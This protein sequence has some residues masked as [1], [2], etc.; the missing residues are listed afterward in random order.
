MD[1]DRCIY[2]LKK[3]SGDSKGFLSTL[4]TEEVREILTEYVC[5]RGYQDK[6][7]YI[8]LLMESYPIWSDLTDCA[9]S[10][11]RTFFK[12]YTI[13]KIHEISMGSQMMQTRELI[14]VY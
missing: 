11:Y 13:E 1:R 6:K 5:D 3:S 7:K 10:Y 2:L 12:I 14:T 9:F 4:S 8:P